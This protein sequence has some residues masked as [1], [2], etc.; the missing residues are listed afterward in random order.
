MIAY[1]PGAD[2][3]AVERLKQRHAGVG[4]DLDVLQK[5]AASHGV[6]VVFYHKNGW[7]FPKHRHVKM[8]GA[9]VR[10]HL[11]LRRRSRE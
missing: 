1:K 11:R 5:G 8:I 7:Q 10:L 4:E 6:I 3:I 2:E 9:D